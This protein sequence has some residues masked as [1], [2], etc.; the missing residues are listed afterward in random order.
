MDK[1]KYFFSEFIYSTN[2]VRDGVLCCG[3]VLVSF[4]DSGPQI[5]TVSSA[6]D[7][8]FLMRSFYKI[9]VIVFEWFPGLHCDVQ[10]AYQEEMRMV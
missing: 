3:I 6:R 1:T 10:G 7:F 2:V 9:L 8:A 4:S 5:F